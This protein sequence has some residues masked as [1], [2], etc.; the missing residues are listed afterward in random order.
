MAH[1][2][3]RKYEIMILDEEMTSMLLIVVL[4]IV[5]LEKFLRKK[6]GWEK[7]ILLSILL[8]WNGIVGGG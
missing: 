7:W 8:S 3:R 2:L 1:R 6:R 4:S 5:L